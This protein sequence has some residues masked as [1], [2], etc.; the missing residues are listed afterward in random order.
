MERLLSR[1]AYKTINAKDCLALRDSLAHVPAIHDALASIALNGM[2]RSLLDHLTPLGDVVDKLTQAIDVDAPALMSEGHYIKSGYNEE[3]DKLREASRNGHQWIADLE[4]KER[5]LTGIK[6]LKIQYNRVF[7]YYIE[8]TKSNYEQVPYR[9][10]RKQTLANCE[11]Y[12]T[13]LLYTSPSPRD[14]R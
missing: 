10:T 9:Y 3:L 1:I 8:V 4:A 14:T 2:L 12:M 6:N 5:E 13:C 7:G 11:R